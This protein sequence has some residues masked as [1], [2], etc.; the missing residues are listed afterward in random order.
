MS[1]YLFFCRIGPGY[2]YE[3]VSCAVVRERRELIS[4]YSQK[5]DTDDEADADV[6]AVDAP[7]PEL[8]WR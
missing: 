5:K 3:G 2:V 7:S 8:S 6:E 4:C 1:S